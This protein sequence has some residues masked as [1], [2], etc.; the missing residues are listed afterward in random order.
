MIA[1]CF[2]AQMVY[3][4][5][6]PHFISVRWSDLPDWMQDDFN[7]VGLA[8]SQSCEVLAQDDLWKNFCAR[9]EKYQR[10]PERL[11][12]LIMSE[13]QPY[14]VVNDNKSNRGLITGYYEPL[15]KGSFFPNKDYPYPVYARPDDLMEASSPMVVDGYDVP[16]SRVKIENDQI[17]PYDTRAEL[18]QE[19]R[20][21]GNELLWVSD[22]IE[23]FFL[24]VQGSGRIEIEDG[25]IIRVGYADHNGY[26]YRSIGRVLIERGELASYEASMQRIRQWAKDNPA[27]VNELLAKNP[28]YIFFRIQDGSQDAGPVGSL[29]VPLTP[30]RSVAVDR[31]YIPLGAPVYISTTM[32]NSSQPLNRL[33]FAQDTGNAIVG[34]VRA[35][36]FWG[37]G[38]RAER[39][40]GGMKQSVRLWVL[41]PR[42]SN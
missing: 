40:A 1:L 23:L 4:Q 25:R 5:K 2:F 33:M 16:I 10:Q 17:V 34:P 35:D 8:L 12:E 32:P 18:M 38:D 42:K 26:P 9:A 29:G 15:L 20:L 31:R 37:Y 28:R 11:R 13:L 30:E 41:L 19:G 7:D 14:K 22:P 3:A 36:Y 6:T 39:L 27:K 24:Q 21:A